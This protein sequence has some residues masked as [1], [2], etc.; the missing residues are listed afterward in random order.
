[1]SKLNSRLGKIEQRLVESDLMQCPQCKWRVISTIPPLDGAAA[2][3]FN[4]P[5]NHWPDCFDET[6][7]CRQCGQEAFRI[8][9]VVP[10]LPKQT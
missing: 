6:G 3:A 8:N 2:H 9:I 1:M 7:D 4:E 10:G 5:P